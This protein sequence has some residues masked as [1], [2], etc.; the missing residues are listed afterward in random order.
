MR[1][2]LVV[3]ALLMPATLGA[4]DEESRFGA[5]LRLEMEKL[6][7]SCDSLKG[8]AGCAVTLITGH[9][10]HV[11]IGS[12]APQNGFG[13]GPALVT[14]YT[15]GDNWRMS[16]NSDAVFAPG[17][18]WRAGTYF[19]S[20]RTAVALPQVVRGGAR[21]SPV[22]SIREYPVFNVYAQAISLP[23]LTFF[24]LGSKSSRDDETAYGMGQTILGSNAIVPLPGALSRRLGLAVLAEANGRFVDI[25][26]GQSTDVPTITA[27]FSDATAPG[28]TAQPGFAQFGEGVRARPDLLGGRL[29][30]A[31]TAQMQQ[32]IAP[33]DSAYSFRRWTLDFDHEIPIYK[34]GSPVRSR[35]T[36][37]PDECAIA[38]TTA[39]CPAITRDRWGTVSARVLAS[40]SSVGGGSAVPFYFQQTL[41]GSDINGVRALA[42]YDDY[43]FRGPHILLFQQT[44]EHSIYG[45]V[46]LWVGAEQG[47]VARQAEGLASGRFLRSVGVG[48]TVRAGGFPALTA[49]W[50]TG[51]SE[52][53]HIAFTVNTSLLGGS[54]RPSLH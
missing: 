17:G 37:G 16:W 26:S 54:A 15:G 3:M 46:G 51:G 49:S 43:R 21:S 20:V 7:E 14:H 31:Y 30:L 33:S 24:G 6:K 32:F 44:V 27:R 22:L 34:T 12:I 2:A 9:P 29:K 50:S 39:A 38:V 18:A 47:T 23:D 41:G 4:Q 48:V 19:K 40:K 11:A 5:E 45:P 1:T 42:S 25:R 10:L 35:E 28:L 13:V 8:I 36:N 53:N 52:G